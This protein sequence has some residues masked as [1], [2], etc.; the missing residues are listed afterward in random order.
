M[1]RRKGGEGEG[2][3]VRHGGCFD[4]M[5][6]TAKEDAPFQAIER[7]GCLDTVKGGVRSRFH[8]VLGGKFDTAREYI[9]GPAV[10]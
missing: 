3:S 7:R 10:S 4:D 5:M 1:P 8:T 6:R 9:R 2:V